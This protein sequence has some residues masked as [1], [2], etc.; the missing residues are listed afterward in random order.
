VAWMSCLS[1][2]RGYLSGIG[3]VNVQEIRRWIVRFFA[4]LAD[5]FVF[6]LTS[7]LPAGLLAIVRY[8]H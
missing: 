7:W 2:T 6:F 8:L 3:G 5:F 4:A 1:H